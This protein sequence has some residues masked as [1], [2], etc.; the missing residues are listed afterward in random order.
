MFV[1]NSQTYGEVMSNK[2]TIIS[3]FIIGLVIKLFFILYLSPD[4]PTRL[5]LP[6]LE[7]S[8]NS[9]SLDPWSTWLRQN[10]DITAFPYGYIMWL[11]LIP[12]HFI[13]DILQ[14]KPLYGYTLALIISDIFILY[15]IVIFIGYK[16]KK[17]I[18]NRII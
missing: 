4:L 13:T 14:I 17:A 12:F 5:Y 16:Y 15:L 1:R 11:T 8:I 10:G 7:T 3:L 2:T 18:I 6:F 9:F